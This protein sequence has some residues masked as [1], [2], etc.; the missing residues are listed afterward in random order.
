MTSFLA[1]WHPKMERG[2]RLEDDGSEGGRLEV[3]ESDGGRLRD[4]ES[5]GDEGGVVFGDVAREGARG[6]CFR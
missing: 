3:D 1:T 4:G 2:G 6:R 5:D